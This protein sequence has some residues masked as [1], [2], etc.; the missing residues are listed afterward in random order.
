MIRKLTP[1]VVVL[2][3][4]VIFIADMKVFGG[5]LP[6]S[7]GNEVKVAAIINLT[8]PAAQFDA[9]KQRTLE[10]AIDR[11]HQ[12]YPMSMVTL[13][14]FDAG[15]GPESTN[16]AVKKAKRWGASYF[17]SGT[18]PTALAIATQVRNAS[19]PVVQMA[20]AANPEFGP[21]RPGEYRLWPDWEHEAFLVADLLKSQGFNKV[22][23]IHSADPYSESLKKALSKEIS[24]KGGVVAVYQQFD[25]ASSPDFRP[26]LTRAKADGAKAIVVFGLPPGIRSLISQMQQVQW[27]G[28]VVGGVNINLT[29]SDFSKTG[30]PGP[31]WSLRTPTMRQKLASGSEADTYRNAYIKKNGEVPAF[32]AVYLADAIYLI[33]A[34][35][36]KAS[37]SSAVDK[38]RKIREIN[39]A[40]GIINITTD[41][42]LKYPMTAEKLYPE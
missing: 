9:I 34:A 7:R 25:P 35:N 3:L 38:T 6:T 20:N 8:G 33:A 23:V 21:P 36:A 26:A 12:L 19:P 22:L 40:S 28:A 4:V 24:K 39:S 14:L 42:I 2:A 31:L 41:G 18:S 1:T 16:V 32:H 27:S 17:L 37:N 15:G 11:V 29:A 13:K 30:L 10:V 5:T